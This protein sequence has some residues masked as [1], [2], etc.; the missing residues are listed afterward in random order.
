MHCDAVTKVWLMRMG[1]LG[2]WVAIQAAAVLWPHMAAAQAPEPDIGRWTAQ[3][4]E[5][6]YRDASREVPLARDEFRRAQRKGDTAAMRRWGG[7]YLSLCAGRRLADDMQA[8]YMALKAD[9]PAASRSDDRAGQ[10]A[11]LL[12][13]VRF[14]I[15]ARQVEEAFSHL[16]LARQLAAQASLPA[17]LGEV[18]LTSAYVQLESARA[19]AASTELVDVLQKSTDRFQQI[20]A[21]SLLANGAMYAASSPEELARVA[22]EAARAQ[23]E[24]NAQGLPWAALAFAEWEA[25]ALARAGQGE[26]GLARL[27]QRQRELARQGMDAGPVIAFRVSRSADLGL[28]LAM[29]ERSRPRDGLC[30][31]IVSRQLPVPDLAGTR[32]SVERLAVLCRAAA[33]DPEVLPAIQALE[34]DARSAVV[35]SSAA[36]E[37]SLWNSIAS[38]YA[39]A[40]AP[41]DAYRSALQLRRSSLRRVGQANEVA[42]AEVESKYQVAT[43]RQENEILRSN[44]VIEAQRRLALLAALAI[45]VLAL[46]VVAV[47]LRLQTRQRQRL[48]GVSDAL[49]EANDRLLALHASRNRLLAAACH[50]LRQ[51][52]HAIGLL[53]EVLSYEALPAQA[54]SVD[55]LRRASAVLA[56]MLDLMIDMTQ[57]ESDRYE[58]RIAPV[59]MDELLLEVQAQFARVAER[60]GLRLH[61]RTS[62][63]LWAMTDRHLL[64]RMLFNLVSNAVKYTRQGLVQVHCEARPAGLRVSVE[65]TG[66]GIP[67]ERQQDIFSEFV[68]LDAL[69]EA[70]Q[71]LGIGLSVVA[72]AARLLGVRVELA[73]AVGRGSTFSV[74]LP[75]AAPGLAGEATPAAP[76]RPLSIV[77]M[78]DDATIRSAMTALLRAQGHAVRDYTALGPLARA[79]EAT[80]ARPDLVIS[81]LHLAGGADGL[82]AIAQLRAFEGWSDVPALLLTGDLGAEVVARA[83]AADV[84]IAYKP[85]SAQR[86]FGLMARITETDPA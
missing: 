35:T 75:A 28:A 40:G 69:R 50:D 33:R 60:K 7:W 39:L 59:P 47:L 20:E 58:P 57:L 54:P 78:E 68:R 41:E 62:R 16:A 36:F 73:S 27:Q 63:G 53:S 43:Q 77:L 86:L 83:A 42:R 45:L 4:R 34:R 85:L 76:A 49:T 52:A 71:G 80:S 26:R 11:A 19:A 14:E 5:A 74:T 37:E 22:L 29:A 15:V 81:D 31:R 67:P 44:Q 46:G 82:D 6:L 48:A 17:L 21:R 79:A 25:N 55:E 9:M 2:I 32:I 30:T 56:D 24:L 72:R 13:M 65:D 51:P 12:G 10:V 64:R 84:V 38:A 70:E 66:V 8:V 61:I 1:P 18:G 3:R 23:D